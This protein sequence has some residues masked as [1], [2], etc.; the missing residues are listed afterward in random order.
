MPST[1][2]VFEGRVV[3]VKGSQSAEEH[4]IW[5]LFMS[6]FTDGV[7]QKKVI[8]GLEGTEVRY[9]SVLFFCDDL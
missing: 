9:F 5:T 1:Y 4:R 3:K 2:L 6:R 8:I 7:F